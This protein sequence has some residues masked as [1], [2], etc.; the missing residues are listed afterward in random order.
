MRS[1]RIKVEGMSCQHCV[2]RVDEALAELEGVV[3]QSV[4]I[5]EVV[6]SIDSEEGGR[7]AVLTAIQS[8]GFTAE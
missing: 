5:G 2:G 7:D 4:Q 8:A 6:V 1:E 3:V